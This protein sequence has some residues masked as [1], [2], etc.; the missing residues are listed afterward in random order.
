MIGID[1]RGAPF[2]VVFDE[3]AQNHRLVRAPVP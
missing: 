2:T 1:T 3:T